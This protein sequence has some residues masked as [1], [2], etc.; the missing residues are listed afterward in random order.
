MIVPRYSASR[1][2][3]LLVGCIELL[4]VR[5]ALLKLMLRVKLDIEVLMGRGRSWR[6]KSGGWV[7]LHTA[8]VRTHVHHKLGSAEPAGRLTSTTGSLRSLCPYT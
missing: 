8:S 5:E 4:V 7:T 6:L 2:P 1:Q 3:K